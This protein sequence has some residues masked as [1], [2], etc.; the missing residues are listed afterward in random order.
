[1]KLSRIFTALAVAT[2]LVA[3]AGIANAQIDKEKSIFT[4]NEP[5]DIGSQTVPA[6]T[7]MIKVVPLSYNRNVVQVTSEDGTKVFATALATP[8]PKKADEQVDNSRFTYYPAAAGHARALR[9]WF[10]PDTPYGQ[11]IVYPKKRAE[12]LAVASKENVI[13]IPEETKEAEYKTVPYTTVS[14]EKSEVAPAAPA[15]E[16]ATAVAESTTTTTSNETQLPR[17]ASDVP[18]AALLGTLALGAA[19]ALHRRAA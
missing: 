4:L 18:A 15:P 14:P 6:G 19:L 8:H 3:S 16:P 13:S 9:T 10:A 12:E 7:Y 2:F 17:T 5:T 1:M 11:D